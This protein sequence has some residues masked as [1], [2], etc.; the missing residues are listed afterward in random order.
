M[1]YAWTRTNVTL[2]TRRRL[3]ALPFRLDL[4]PLGDVDRITRAIRESDLPDDFAEFLE[5]GGRPAAAGT[6]GA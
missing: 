4:R 1:S 5:T 6:G 3:A 2:E